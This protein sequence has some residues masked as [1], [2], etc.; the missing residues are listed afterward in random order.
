MSQL[1]A[2]QPQWLECTFVLLRED[3]CMGGG[4]HQETPRAVFQVQPTLS[5][6]FMFLRT[7][8]FIGEILPPSVRYLV[9][10]CDTSL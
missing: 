6:K 2:L 10:F 7:E 8:P 3:I 4:F 5:N 1:P 9:S